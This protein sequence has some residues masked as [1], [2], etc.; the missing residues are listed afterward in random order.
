M[1]RARTLHPY[2][3]GGIERMAEAGAQENGLRGLQRVD[4]RVG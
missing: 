1:T 2:L 4:L 3:L